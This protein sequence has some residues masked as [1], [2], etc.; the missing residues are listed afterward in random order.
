[1]KKIVFQIAGVRSPNDRSLIETELD[2]LVGVKNVQLDEKTGRCAVEFDET[3]TSPGNI[4]KA[5]RELGFNVRSVER[6]ASPA[7]NE[8]T[9]FVQGMHCASCEVL[10]EKKLLA[11]EKIKSVEASAAKGEVLIECEGEAPTIREL[12]RIFEKDDYIFSDEPQKTKENKEGEGLIILGV[13]A[14]VII[15][16]LSLNKLG[17]AQLVNVG[18]ASSLPA[19]FVFGLL[20]GV[21]SCAALVGGIVL[22]MSK[23]WSNLYSNEKSVFQKLQPHLIFNAGRLASYALLGA[24]LGIIGSKLQISFRFTSLLVIGISIMMIFLALQMLGVKAF[25]RFQF[26]MPKFTSRYIADES[27][28]KGK[29]MPFTMGA[30]TFFLPCGFTITAQG[31]A[32]VSGNAVQGALIMFLFALGTLPALLAIGFSSVKFSSRP[33]LALRFAKIAGVL[34]LFFALFNINNQMNV[35]GYSNFTDFF[36]QS[37]NANNARTNNNDDNLAPIVEGKQLLKMDALASGYAPNYFKVRAGVPVRWE[38]TDQ[39][40]SGCTNAVISRSLFDGEIDLTAGQTS[41]KEFTPQKAGKYKFSCWMGMISGVIEVVD[42]NG[43]VSTASANTNND[44]IPSGAK[45]CGCGGG[46]SASCGAG[47]QNS[48]L[49][50]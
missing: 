30:L 47:G 44:L 7:I 45:G 1:M 15:G 37:N 2:V 21:S 13:A 46:G 16:F 39:G 19:F 18:S 8:H 40:T 36:R 12:N 29:Y 43:V 33:H 35:L 28:F 49:P 42:S 31:L 23:Q 5:V 14:L 32:L 41:I 3:K 6:A 10:I 4:S 11:V 9:Y 20:A 38:I 17:L 22:S 27:N 34:V 26:T 48:R 25:R 24:L 50:N